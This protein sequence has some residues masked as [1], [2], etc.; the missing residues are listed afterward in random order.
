MS[1]RYT[2]EEKQHA[3]QQLDANNGD[4][5]LTSAQTGIT[6]RT[7]YRWN[8][9]RELSLTQNPSPLT[10]L[11]TPP[12]PISDDTAEVLRDL[13]QRILR[14]TYRLIDAIESSIGDKSS[15][16]QIVSAISQLIDRYMKLSAQLPSQQENEPFLRIEYV[17]VEDETSD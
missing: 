1:R 12:P 7:L 8:K 15:V 16:N 3:L 2:E 6:A 5:S 13:Q 9:N 17:E 10:T 14:E 11:T 4:V